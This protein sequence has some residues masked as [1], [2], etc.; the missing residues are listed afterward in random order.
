MSNAAA[1]TRERLQEALDAAIFDDITPGAICQIT[2]LGAPTISVTAGHLTSLD[3]M[4]QPLPPD[5]RE[6]VTDETIYDLASVSKIFTS[7]TLLS[8]ADDGLVDLDVSVAEWLP[9]FDTQERSTVTIAHLLSHTSGLPPTNPHAV[10]RCVRDQGTDHAHWTGPQRGAVIN[11]VLN[12]PLATPAGNNKVYSCLGYIAA[13]AIAEAATGLEWEEL[14]LSRVLAPLQ[15]LG[16][17]FTPAVALTAPTEYQPHLGRGM[18]RGVVHDEIAHALG[19]P[20]GNAGLFAPAHDVTALGVGLANGLPGVLSSRSFERLW[21][22][23]LPRMLGPASTAA[24]AEIGYAQSLGLRIG[25]QSWMSAAGRNARGHTGF[26]GTSVL[27]DADKQVVVVLLTNRVH[28]DRDRAD[29]TSLR[30]TVA[31]IAYGT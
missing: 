6:A 28:P 7:I 9:S 5:A 10:R 19:G 11:D 20:A 31:S 4:G 14:V 3:G 12:L 16:T 21:N 23:Q 17:T 1:G 25:Q 30:N 18:V 26:T 2:R 24:E 15:L 13:M 29:V 8:L 27:V 22:N